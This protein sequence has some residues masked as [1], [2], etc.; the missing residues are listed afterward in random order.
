MTDQL[1]E[2]PWSLI[3]QAQGGFAEKREALKQLL[4]LY[5]QPVA[6]ALQQACSLSVAD[7]KQVAQQF[8]EKLLTPEALAKV[9]PEQINFRTHLKAEL[10]DFVERRENL[11]AEPA[12]KLSDFQ[13][14]SPME[15]PASEGE[16]DIV[17]D[18]QWML[19]LILRAVDKLQVNDDS[20]NQSTFDIFSSVDVAAKPATVDE[21]A[22]GLDMDVAE[23][24][25]RLFSARRMLR[26]YLMSDIAGYTANRDHAREELQW[27]LP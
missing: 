17:F 20:E 16:V 11:L 25:N 24:E 5:W 22:R 13:L 23:V 27:L 1:P 6:N 21:L 7:S 8:L 14:T 4:E 19:L 12:R 26:G 18:E 3:A 2:T 9:D 10:L 15:L